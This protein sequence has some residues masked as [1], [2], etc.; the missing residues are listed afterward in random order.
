MAVPEIGA[1]RLRGILLPVC[2]DEAVDMIGVVPLPAAAPHAAA[3]EAW[4]DE[5][6]H[7][8]LE[9]MARDREGR[10]DPVLRRPWART[11]LVFAQRHVAGWDAA[12]PAPAE[13]A[14]RGRPWL[15]GVAAYARGRDYH[16]VLLAGVRRALAALREALAADLGPGPAAALRAHAAVDTGPY[17]ERELAWQA[18]LGFFGKNTCLIH[19]RLGSGFCLGVALVEVAVTG[20]DAAPRPLVGPPAA[21]A[22]AAPPGEGPASLCGRCRLC[23]D[24]CP[25]GALD[26]AFSLDAGR[27]L[28]TWTIEWRG[29]APADAR[30]AQGGQVFGCDICQAVCPWNHKALRLA[31]GW[32]PRDDYAPLPQHAELDLAG[33]IDLDADE[34][35]RR[36]RRTPLWRAHPEGLRRNALV[37]AANS[38]RADLAA[39]ARE[40]AAAADPATAAVAAWA[41]SVLADGVDGEEEG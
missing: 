33:L 22:A 32:T 36:F 19:P 1:D 3:F 21:G 17:L 38:G 8:G 27:C 2:R 24:A 10:A 37:A 31:G 6:R 9:Y 25:T 14:A 35:E 15:D 5:G 34:F 13:G 16:D 7:G 41:L 28:S 18:G 4:L 26:R 40:A 29:G 39:A 11:A 12:D 30:A 23:Q 20:L